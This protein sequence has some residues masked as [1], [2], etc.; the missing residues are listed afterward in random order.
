MWGA[1]VTE[2]NKAEGGAR[3]AASLVDGPTAV[4]SLRLRGRQLLRGLSHSSDCPDGGRWGKMKSMWCDGQS[5]QEAPTRGCAV[6]K[7]IISR[8][9]GDPRGELLGWL[10]QRGRNQLSCV[11]KR[12]G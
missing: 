6:V 4:V 8:V 3:Q 2:T 7:S 12:S 1:A 11:H 10:Q 9:P 5:R